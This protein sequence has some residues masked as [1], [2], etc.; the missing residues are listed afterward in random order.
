MQRRRR[1]R[2]SMFSVPL[3]A[4]RNAGTGTTTTACV[5]AQLATLVHM[6]LSNMRRL[7]LHGWC[8]APEVCMAGPA[9]CVAPGTNAMACGVNHG[10]THGKDRSH[11]CCLG[12]ATANV[13]EGGR[14]RRS[15]RSH[16]SSD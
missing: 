10:T 15:G 4:T 12:P 7:R 6:R 8:G 3:P 2:P 5:G 11:A 1:G 16:G 14:A 13:T 9:C